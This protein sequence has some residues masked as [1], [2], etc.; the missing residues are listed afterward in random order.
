[1]TI[2]VTD[3]IKAKFWEA[4]AWPGPN[5]L[6]VGRGLAAVLAIMERD[7]VSRWGTIT[8]RVPREFMDTPPMDG[9]MDGFKKQVIEHAKYMGAEVV[10]IDNPEVF[11]DDSP[12]A[13]GD[14]AV[15]KWKIRR[16]A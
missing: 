6:D 12:P 9:F 7:Y 16:T 3:E 5:D 2:E 13:F 1:M 15:L 8:E 14:Y 4:A 11:P 10:D